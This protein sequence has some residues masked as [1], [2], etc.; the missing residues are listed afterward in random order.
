MAGSRLRFAHQQD[1][2]WPLDAAP[3]LNDNAMTA[4]KNDSSENA[5]RRKEWWI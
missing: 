4:L 5:R 2:G 1:E 3:A